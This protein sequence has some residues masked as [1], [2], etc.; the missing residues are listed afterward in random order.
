M[1]LPKQ[2]HSDLRLA[3]GLLARA[4]YTVEMAPSCSWRSRSRNPTGAKA[5]RSIISLPDKKASLLG[6][7]DWLS[8]VSGDS[9][10]IWW[11]IC[12][13]PFWPRSDLSTPLTSTG[14]IAASLVAVVCL[15]WAVALLSCSFCCCSGANTC[16]VYRMLFIIV[17]FR[18]LGS[19]LLLVKTLEKELGKSARGCRTVGCRREGEAD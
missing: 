14:R 3:G 12:D 2:F 11:S 1:L 10:N 19:P 5:R 17:R 4:A 16:F 8:S 18:F 15:Q 7:T 13:V 9:L 6:Q